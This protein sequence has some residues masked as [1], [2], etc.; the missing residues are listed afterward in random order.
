MIWS[1]SYL[2]VAR[3]TALT[4]RRLQRKTAPAWGHLG[5]PNRTPDRGGLVPRR[6]FRALDTAKRWQSNLLGQESFPESLR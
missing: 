3:L 5:P 2:A 1:N 4:R 6:V